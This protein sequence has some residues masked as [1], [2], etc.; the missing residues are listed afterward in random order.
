MCPPHLQKRLRPGAPVST[1]ACWSSAT[2]ARRSRPCV[3]WAGRVAGWWSAAR[4]CAPMPRSRATS[5]RRGRIRRSRMPR[6]PRHCSSSWRRARTSTRSF[7]SAGSRS[8]A[9]ARCT[10][11]LPRPL[12][13]AMPDPRLVD[14]CDDKTALLDVAERVGVPYPAW[15]VVAGRRGAAGGDGAHRLSLRGQARGGRAPTVR[16]E[17]PDPA[18]RRRPRGAAG[19]MAARMAASCSSSATSRACGTICTWSPRTAACC[20]ASTR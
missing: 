20:A 12:P 19:G 13:V 9:C 11:Q 7:P 5:T 18:R 17:G 3:R 6:S 2:I 15:T 8:C 10:A 16:R 14:I 1:R 4:P